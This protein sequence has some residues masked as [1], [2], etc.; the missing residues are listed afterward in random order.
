MPRNIVCFEIPAFEIAVARLQDSSLRDRPVA[1]APLHR[2]RACVHELSGEARREGLTAG[3]SVEQARGLCPSLRL[4]SHDPLR[5]RTA[6]HQ[7][8]NLVGRVAPVWE[9]VAPGHLFLDLSGTGRLFGPATDTAARLEHEVRQR[10]GLS[11]MMGVASN[12]LVSQAAATLIEPSHLCDILPGSEPTFMAPLP[13]SYLPRL[14]RASV[15]AGRPKLLTLLDDLHLRTLGEIA[16]IPLS[17]LERVCGP[18]A[19]LLHDR[20]CGI[21]PSPICP[22]VQRPQVELSVTL[23]PDEVDDR[24]LLGLLYSRVETLCR[25]LRQ[26]RRMCERVTLGI[27][28]VDYEEATRACTFHSATYWEVDVYPALTDLFLRLFHRRVRIRGLTLTAERLRPA[29]EQLSLFQPIPRTRMQRVALAL[30]HL[31]DRFGPKAIAFGRVR[32]EP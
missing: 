12:K 16:A 2:P 8:L 29:E 17:H 27:S 30:D 32:A 3:M 13:V 11:G 20:A 6:Q 19:R 21:D 9:P 28:Y 23:D 25:Q 26:Q 31:R 5:V 7:I 14:S 24:H 18:Y 4:I 10:H 15:G 1:V 22:P